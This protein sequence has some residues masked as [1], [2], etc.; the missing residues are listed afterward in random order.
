[1]HSISMHEAGQVVDRFMS[2]FTVHGNRNLGS[3]DF[4]QFP[5]AEKTQTTRAGKRCW[6][7]STG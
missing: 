1:M 3:I 2:K 5:G 4:C 7:T 6:D